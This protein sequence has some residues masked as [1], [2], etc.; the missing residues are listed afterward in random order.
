MAL[1]L[2]DKWI[3]DFWLTKA[4]DGFHMFYL[5]APRSIADP[6]QRHWNVS[7]GHARSEDLIDWT[8][9]PDALSPGPPG[10]WDDLTTWTGS[11]VEHEGTWYLFYTGTS[12]AEDGAIQR[13]GLATSD[14]LINFERH[15][16]EPLLETDTRWYET[17]DAG[18]WHDQAWRDPWVF[19]GED[20]AFHMTITAR[21]T[22]GPVKGRGVVAH[23]VSD[24]LVNWTTNPPITSQDGFGQTE[25]S[26]LFPYRGHW[27]LVFCSDIATQ[28]DKRRDLGPGTGTYYIR[29]DRA[30]GPFDLKEAVPLSA[31][32]HGS[33]YAGKLVEH[34]GELLLL[35]WALYE[36]D[37]G[38]VGEIP[39][40]VAL[41]VDQSGELSLAGS[42]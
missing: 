42:L 41:S 30:T 15:G 3:W 29:S 25:V 34:D 33:T 16:S 1:R 24:D 4:E 5:Q 17:F 38:F 10:S 26:Q 36:K 19:Q 32:R 6:E 31:D 12:R 2:D 39:D 13:I 40:P 27:Y 21:A 8:V 18:V 28:S 7:I 14:D 37:G 20:G 35:N 9:L 11:I 23:A 22:S